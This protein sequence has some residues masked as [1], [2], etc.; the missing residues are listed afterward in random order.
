MSH[1]ESLMWGVSKRNRKWVARLADGTEVVTDSFLD[2]V[3]AVARDANELWCGTF[4]AGAA[5][6]DGG[7]AAFVEGV[8]DAE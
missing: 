2:A 1:G 6:T 8:L 5:G 7:A 3:Q 4:Y